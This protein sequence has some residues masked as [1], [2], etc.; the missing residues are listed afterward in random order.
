MTHRDQV[1]DLAKKVRCLVCQGQTIDT[2]DTVFA[3]IILTY[4][5]DRIHQGV[6]PE[7]ILETLAASY[8]PE[9]YQDPPLDILPVYLWIL[10]IIVLGVGGYRFW[11][12]LR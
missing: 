5:E 2:S 7:H 10:P 4:L 12:G 9:I 1:G 6:A 8:G 11:K 3:H